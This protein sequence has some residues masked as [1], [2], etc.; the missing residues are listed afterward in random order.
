MDKTKERKTSLP[1]V[2]RLK[3]V[4]RSEKLDS[5]VVKD[6]IQLATV[7]GLT[8]TNPSGL[9]TSGLGVTA[10][11]A[12]CVVVL[13]NL[14]AGTQRHLVNEDRKTVTC[15]AWAG[16]SQHLATGESGHRPQVKVSQ[17][18]G[19]GIPLNICCSPPCSRFGAC[20]RCPPS[21]R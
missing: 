10:Y 2:R 20:P 12:G 19:S 8:V 18:D 4:R 11:P 15:L 7:L 5:G 9:A 16:D 21:P 3:T 13:A 17:T 6:D 1:H 14:A